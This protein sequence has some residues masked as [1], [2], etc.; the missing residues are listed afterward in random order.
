MLGLMQDTPLLLS[1]ILDYA[2][3]FHGQQEIVSRTL[4]GGIHR[5][6]F[7]DCEARTKQLANALT[8]LGVKKGDRVGTL[9]WNGYRHLEAWYGISGIGAVCHT[10]NPRLFAEQI[11]YIIN[12]AE[13]SYLLVDLTF[14]PL[15]EAL[16]DKLPSVKAVILLT[17]EANMPETSLSN[18]ICYETLIGKEQDE[19]TWPVFDENEASSLCYTSGTTGNPKGV[20]YSHRSSVI[21][22]MMAARPDVMN[23]AADSIILSIV[24]MFHANAWGIPY[25]ALMSGSKLVFP[26]MHMDGKNVY[27]LLEK[28]GITYTAAVPTIWMMLL[29]Y[30]EETGKKVETL[31]EVIIGGAAPPKSMIDAFQR[32]YNVNVVHA[33]GMTETSPVGTVCYFS[34]QH[35][36]LPYEERLKLQC[37]QGRGVYGVELKITDDNN[38]EL[39]WDGKTFGNL[40]VRGPWVV[41]RYFKEEESATDEDNWFST[42][43]V[44]TIDESGFMQITDRSKDVIK[45]GGEWISSIDL[46]NTAVGHPEVQEAA[47]IGVYHP[48]WDERPLLIVVRKAGSQ[49]TKEQILDYLEGKIAKW[50]MPDDVQF[51][52][53]IPHTATGKILKMA[54]RKTFEDYKLP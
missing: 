17:D 27:E 26:G 28:E 19:F 25:A 8:K 18:V 43:D 6:T 40:K 48:K 44:A 46:E 11:V 14:L 22:S 54:L 9:A 33:W 41:E 36:K 5:Y 52:E 20:L 32:K 1:G 51:I 37:K 49:V 15:L 38:N 24:P 21:H 53:E 45:S 16:Q 4:D 12:H 47:V 42:G 31:E 13:D 30:L 10:I 29:Q 35:K 2:A 39:P 23:L 34:A 7:K 50:W 3:Q